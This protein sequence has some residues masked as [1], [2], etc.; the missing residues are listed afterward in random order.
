[1]KKSFL[2]SIVLF[3]GFLDHATGQLLSPEE[4]KNA[5][6]NKSLEEALKEPKNV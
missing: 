1:M 2:I 6:V 3:S 5:T 4:L